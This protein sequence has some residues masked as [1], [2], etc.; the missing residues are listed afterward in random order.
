[1]SH[2]SRM[3]YILFESITSL[4]MEKTTHYVVACCNFS[5]PPVVSCPLG[6][7]I[8]FSALIL[9]TFCLLHPLI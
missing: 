1:M 6:P 3:Y 8:L 9:N 5:R 4:K 7:D 2:L